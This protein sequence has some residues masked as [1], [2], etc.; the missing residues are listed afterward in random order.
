MVY[1]KYRVTVSSSDGYS[2][3]TSTSL[4]FINVTGLVYGTAYAVSVYAEVCKETIIS[5]NFS[6]CDND[7]SSS[8]SKIPSSHVI[9]PTLSVDPV[10][11]SSYSTTLTSANV[12]PTVTHQPT[13]NISSGYIWLIIV[14]GF[15][16][17]A[18]VG[19]LILLTL[20]FNIKKSK[21]Y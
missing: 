12:T 6:P 13:S 4:S 19:V 16:L 21:L 2:L 1:S 18:L 11:S 5:R 7:M 20:C 15:I 8:L 10:S 14:T 9:F 3:N 17:I